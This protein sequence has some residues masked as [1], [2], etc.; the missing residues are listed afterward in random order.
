[1]NRRV[2]VRRTVALSVAAKLSHVTEAEVPAPRRNLLYVFGD[3][4]RAC[5]MPGKPYSPV[6]APTFKAFAKQ[7]FVM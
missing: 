6:V 5:S 7:N 3:Q 1:M 2:F 4:H